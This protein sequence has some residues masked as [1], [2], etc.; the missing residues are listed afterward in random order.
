[1][2]TSSASFIEPPIPFPGTIHY[3]DGTSLRDIFYE[4]EHGN[5]DN[6]NQELLTSSGEELLTSDGQKILLK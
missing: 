4:L 3:P 1:M 6:D 2:T 5:Q